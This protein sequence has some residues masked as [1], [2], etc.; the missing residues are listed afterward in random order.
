MEPIGDYI[1]DYVQQLRG[2]ES[3]FYDSYVVYQW[4]GQGYMIEYDDSRVDLRTKF[5]RKN[6]GLT[7]KKVHAY[8]KH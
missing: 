1:Q 5:A 8:D 2:G 3:F 6:L 4:N 7:N